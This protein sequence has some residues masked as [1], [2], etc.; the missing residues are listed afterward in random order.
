MVLRRLRRR[1]RGDHGMYAGESSISPSTPEAV[2]F[3]HLSDSWRRHMCS[4]EFVD[5]LC[6][7]V[8]NPALEELER[9]FGGERWAREIAPSIIL[10]GPALAFKITVLKTKGWELTGMVARINEV[11]NKHWEREIDRVPPR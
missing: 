11:F 6:D 5:D 9:C 8:M 3:I 10:E 2:A 7:R 4:A 1:L